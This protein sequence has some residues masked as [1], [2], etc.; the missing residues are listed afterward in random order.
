MIPHLN[1]YISLENIMFINH[2]DVYNAMQEGVFFY[3]WNVVFLFTLIFNPQYFSCS[4][5]SLP[6]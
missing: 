5:S 3:A 4:P 6:G 1:R 2:Y